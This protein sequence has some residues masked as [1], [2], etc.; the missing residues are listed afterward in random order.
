MIYNCGI[1]SSYCC[2]DLYNN[3]IFPQQSCFALFKNHFDT[4]ISAFSFLYNS[5]LFMATIGLH[6]CGSCFYFSYFSLSFNLQLITSSTGYDN[7]LPYVMRK[8]LDIV[9]QRY[10]KY[11][12]VIILVLKY[13]FAV[14]LQ[15]ERNQ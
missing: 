1:K 11:I 5:L 7:F 14:M 13:I 8:I 9:C 3:K 12:F 2:T 4:S 6:V 15:R 10:I